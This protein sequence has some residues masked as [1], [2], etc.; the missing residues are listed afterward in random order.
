MDPKLS[1]KGSG[2]T[3]FQNHFTLLPAFLIL[4]V[5]RVNSNR[6]K[7][8]VIAVLGMSAGW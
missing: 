3:R 7:G 2:Y 4:K 6:P 1:I 5:V 8:V